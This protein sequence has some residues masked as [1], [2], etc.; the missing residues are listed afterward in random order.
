MGVVK[1]DE[2]RRSVREKNFIRLDCEAG[3]IVWGFILSIGSNL[4]RLMCGGSAN[5]MQALGR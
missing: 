5:R 1:Q 4:I 3:W 2:E